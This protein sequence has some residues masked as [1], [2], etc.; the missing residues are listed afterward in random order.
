[1]ATRILGLATARRQKI[2]VICGE[3]AIG[4]VVNF[5]GCTQREG[6]KEKKSKKEKEKEEDKR[7]EEEEMGSE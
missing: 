3:I 1:M 4:S 6:E 5:I 2:G 7:E